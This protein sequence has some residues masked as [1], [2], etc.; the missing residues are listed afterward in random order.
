MDD[1]YVVV[2]N[3]IEL[4]AEHFDFNNGQDIKDFE[5]YVKLVL[6]DY[7]HDMAYDMDC[8]REYYES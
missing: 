2:N 5:R 3:M 7:C 1:K 8:L 4:M 6:E